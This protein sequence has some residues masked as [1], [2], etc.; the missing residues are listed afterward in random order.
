[1]KTT[2]EKICL[3]CVALG[4]L[5][6][7]VLLVVAAGFALLGTGEA[8]EKTSAYLACAGLVVM[9]LSYL[10]GRAANRISE[11]LN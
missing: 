7:W 3:F 5:L 8:A 6:P 2:A 11:R 1:M 9:L 10:F 4:G